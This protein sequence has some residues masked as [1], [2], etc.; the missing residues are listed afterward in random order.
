MAICAGLI[1]VLPFPDFAE[2]ASWSVMVT[3][4][5]LAVHLLLLIGNQQLFISATKHLRK[6]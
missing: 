5:I 1:H 3:R 2:D 4:L 6:E